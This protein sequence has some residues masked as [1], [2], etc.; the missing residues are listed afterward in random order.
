MLEKRLLDPFADAWVLS[1]RRFA[2]AR[3]FFSETFHQQ[4]LR[5]EGFEVNFVQDNVSHSVLSGTVRGL[6]YQKSPQ[7]QVKLVQVL[8]GAIYDVIVDLREGSPTYKHWAGVELSLENGQQ[9]WVPEGFAHGFCTLETNT[10]VQ[11]K[12][13]AYYAPVLDAGI[14][15]ADPE[16]AILWP[17]EASQAILSDKDQALPV[18]ADAEP[19]FFYVNKEEALT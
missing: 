17:V 8:Q 2:D 19:G 14:F 3:G 4:R 5:D 16:L 9:L 1:P 6:H 10:V 12:V 18:L 13:S 15:W 7:A 11:Y